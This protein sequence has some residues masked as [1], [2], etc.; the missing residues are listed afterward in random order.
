M[1]Y[2]FHLETNHYIDSMRM[3]RTQSLDESVTESPG[4]ASLLDGI[5]AG[6]VVAAAAEVYLGKRSMSEA[7]NDK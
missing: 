6:L 4:R 5:G 2:R 3:L 1:R 7:R